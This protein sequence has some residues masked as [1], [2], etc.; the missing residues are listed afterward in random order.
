MNL[1]IEKKQS[2]AVQQLWLNLI[3]GLKHTDLLVY[4]N[5]QAYRQAGDDECVSTSLR[6]GGI[7]FFVSFLSFS[8]L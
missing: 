8:H 4:V 6:T 2:H 5:A 7:V 1:D 3:Q